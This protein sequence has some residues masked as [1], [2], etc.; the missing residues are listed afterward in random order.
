MNLRYMTAVI[1]VFA[2]VAQPS[3]A[4]VSGFYDSAEKITTIL[5]SDQVADA[6]RQA[7]IG[8]ISEIGKTEAGNAFWQIRT[9]DCDLG[10][11]LKAVPPDGP[12]KVT[13]EVISVTACE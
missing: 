7:P 1:V 6:V 3:N 5:A 2:S 4:M 9:Q 11:E 8:S 10:V 13:Y 12:G